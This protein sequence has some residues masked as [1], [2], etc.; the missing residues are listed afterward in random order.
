MRRRIRQGERLVLTYR[1]KPVARLDPVTEAEPPTDD[2]IPW[3]F[4]D[5][6]SF[7]VMRALRLQAALTSD[8]H[9]EQAG[10]RVLLT[11]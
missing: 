6:L 10:F 7:V 2:P 1:G 3:S 8:V 4:T 5:C 9:F 11:D